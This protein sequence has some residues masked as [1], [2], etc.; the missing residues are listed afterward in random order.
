[1]SFRGVS[2]STFVFLCSSK[3]NY[4][5]FATHSLQLW[6]KFEYSVDKVVDVTVYFQIR[7]EVK[8]D[9][10]I[11]KLK[12]MTIKVLLGSVMVRFIIRVKTYPFM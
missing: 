12:K 5:T 10:E 3:H 8:R 2:E 1:M 7:R 11:T 9:Y 6:L 4:T